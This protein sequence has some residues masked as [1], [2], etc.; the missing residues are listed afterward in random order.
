MSSIFL[1]Q[2]AVL[3]PASIAAA[4][5][6]LRDRRI[7]NLLCLAIA[8]AGV[9]ALWVSLGGQRVPLG[10]AT[11]VVGGLACTPFYLMRSMG[12]GDVKLVAATSVWWSLTQFLVAFVAM[13][14]CG[15][16]LALGYLCFSRAT[17]HVPYGAAIAASTVGTVF[18]F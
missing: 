1:L 8:I 3:I 17:T 5:L 12:G 11:G 18:F 7:P 13:A 6:D 14:I 15:A 10:I 16:V 2:V 9:V 4:V